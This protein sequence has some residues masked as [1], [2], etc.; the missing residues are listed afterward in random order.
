MFWLSTAALLF[1]FG[2]VV[3]KYEVFPYRVI[4]LAAEGLQAVRTNSPV[5]D[6]LPWYYIKVESPA[7]P[8]I[9][10]P[11]GAQPGLNLVTRF[12]A[13]N[14]ITIEIMDL[15]GNKV[16]NWDVDWF[17][18]WP[19]AAHLPDKRLPK[20][21]PG[22]HAHGAVI[23]DDGDL[24]FNYNHLGL[25]R[26]DRDGEVVW[27][28]PYQTHHSVHLHDDGNLWVCGQRVRNDINP[29]IPGRLRPYEEYTLLEI[30]PD[31][32][33]VNEWSVQDLLQ[34]ER[35]GLFY[36]GTPQ[37][38][39]HARDDRMH[40]NDVE[41]FPEHME[42]GFFKRGDVLVSVKKVNTVFVFNSET[43]EIKFISTGRF[44]W[45][46][47]P[48]FV[49]GNTIS[50][51]D[52]NKRRAHGVR[53]AQSRII[54]LNTDDQEEVCYEGTEEKPFYTG[55]MGKHQWLE[56]G[57]LLITSSMEGRA[58]EVNNN[59]ETVW[60]HYNYVDEGVVG[61]TDEVQRL[62]ERCTEIFNGSS[63]DMKPGA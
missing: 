5:G 58:F 35:P 15:D 1:G 41:P 61:V 62:P 11:G 54:T 7:P 60:E 27:R 25:V 2:L 4:A 6:K 47:D 57:N 12:A 37:Q 20:S 36:M 28:L 18:I 14:R 9:H 45:Q 32:E 23:L 8:G 42:E 48:D 39:V 46:H 34:D 55:I 53:N 50:V 52:N 16:H 56:N 3:G 40:L 33:I 63:R 22:T 24:V 51:F 17:T 59:G 38:Y 19:D 49:D 31:G 10:N 21:R 30:T 44:V 26:L 43:K 29:K 13:D